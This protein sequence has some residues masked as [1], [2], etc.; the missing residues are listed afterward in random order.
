MPSLAAEPDAPKS[1]VEHNATETMVLQLAA[2]QGSIT[3]ADVENVLAVSGSTASRL[4]RRMVKQS[5]LMQIGSAKTTKYLL[6]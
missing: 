1:K 4:L 3:R 6:P 2:K 5:I